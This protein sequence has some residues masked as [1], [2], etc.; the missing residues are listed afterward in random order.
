[1]F[2]R[3]K[4]R[5][6]KIN[7]KNTCR[8][9]KYLYICRVNNDK[10]T[11]HT[12]NNA[13]PKTYKNMNALTEFT[14]AYLAPLQIADSDVVSLSTGAYDTTIT[15]YLNKRT[16]KLI[17]QMVSDMLATLDVQE[18]GTPIVRF[19]YLGSKNRMQIRYCLQDAK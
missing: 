6:M 15:L 9:K 7:L 12:M 18:N 14:A 3:Q 11:H 19:K 5:K 1:M 4:E 16:G 10:Q 17:P 13:T 8:T 2:F